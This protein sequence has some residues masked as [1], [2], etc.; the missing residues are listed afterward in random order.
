M[1]YCA[2][3][4]AQ[5]SDDATFCPTCGTQVV[6]PAAAG[7]QPA[8]NQ[9]YA[10]PAPDFSD[11][12]AD[13]DANKVFGILAYIGILVLVTI[14]AAPKNSRYSK[15]HANQGLVLL[16]AEVAVSI[17]LVIIF[18]ILGVIAAATYSWGLVVALSTIGSIVWAV[19]GIGSLVLVILGIVNAANGRLKPLPITGKFTILK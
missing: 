1:I 8:G 12:A 14:F 10:Q 2:K 15:F 11:P 19:Y 13:A 16:I 4:G 17:V 9:G 3:C 18:A 7:Q 6:R 5:L